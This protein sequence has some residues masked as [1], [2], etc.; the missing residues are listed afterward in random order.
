MLF[1]GF[2]LHKENNYLQKS[3]LGYFLQYVNQNM[4][5]LLKVGHISQCHSKSRS[6]DSSAHHKLSYHAKQYMCNI[7]SKFHHDIQPNNDF[8]LF[9]QLDPGCD[10]T[11]N[12]FG[13]EK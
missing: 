3:V 5:N 4:A 10:I 6:P 11:Q 9:K 13:T 12:I 1:G 2:K 7:W 8:I